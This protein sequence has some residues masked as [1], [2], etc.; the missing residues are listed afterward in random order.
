MNKYIVYVNA[1]IIAGIIAAMA[2]APSLL[3]SNPVL[4]SSLGSSSSGKTE[5]CNGEKHTVNYCG[6]FY[7]GVGDC[8]DGNS[9]KGYDKHHWR[10]GYK[11]GWD[12][13][14]GPVC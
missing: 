2:L 13:V 5:Q 4:A 10:T 8:E 12:S 1:S 3:M 11:A 7:R 14:M 6:G 9:Y